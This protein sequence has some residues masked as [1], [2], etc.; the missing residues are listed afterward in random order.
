MDSQGLNSEPVVIGKIANL[1]LHLPASL[2]LFVIEIFIGEN[3]LVAL[4]PYMANDS[5]NHRGVASRV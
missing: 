2:W 1:V 5:N 3:R 4:S